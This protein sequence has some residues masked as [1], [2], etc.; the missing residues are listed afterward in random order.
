MRLAVID[1]G[2]NTFNLLII[3]VE[4]GTNFKSVYKNRISVKLGEGAIN[5]GF[6]SPLAFQRALE[7]I[8]A[9]K[10]LIKEHFTEKVLAFAT[11]AIR[12][13]SNGNELVKK[14]KDEF[15]ISLTVIDGEREADLIFLGVKEAVKLNETISL[16]MDIG[17][18]STELILANNKKVYWKGSFRIGAARL[19]DKFLPSNPIADT[20]INNI[21]AYIEEQLA[22]FFEIINLYPPVE[23]IGSSGAFDSLIEMINGELNGEPLLDEKTSYEINLDHYNQI[24]EMVRSST[25]EGRKRIKGLIPIRFDMIVIS[26]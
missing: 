19:L 22:A 20:E 4:N 21:H 17:G 3:D 15:D 16:I 23:L 6:I 13:A 8:R 26:C 7:A 5:Q 2:T 14:V 10:F 24:S 9:F 12:D 1:C 11:S 18:G 25:F